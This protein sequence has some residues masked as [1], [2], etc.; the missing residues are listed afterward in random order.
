MFFLFEPALKAQTKEKDRRDL[1]KFSL[2]SKAIYIFPGDFNASL[3]A[4]QITSRSM[5]T[6]QLG[7]EYNVV[8]EGDLLF[9]IGGLIGIPPVFHFEFPIEGGS[10]YPEFDRDERYNVGGYGF[11]S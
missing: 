4:Y 8:S 9:S 10:V 2:V 5:I 11:Y 7:I 6:G 3:G 1:S